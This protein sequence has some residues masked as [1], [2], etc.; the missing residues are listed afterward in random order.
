MN[1]IEKTSVVHNDAVSSPSSDNV[2]RDDASSDNVIHGF[3]TDIEHLP[4]G[5]YYSPFFIGS[6]LAVALSLTCGV[7]AFGY[8]APLLTQ[9][10]AELGPDPMFVWV[11]LVYNVMLSVGLVLVGRLS[12]IFGRRYFF[13]GGQVIGVLGCVVCAKSTSVPMLIGKF[14]AKSFVHLVNG[15]LQVETCFW[16]SRQHRNCRSTSPWA[17]W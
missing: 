5:Y 2:V 14:L 16:V 1:E 11:S 13:I 7:A 9:I 3:E 15:L 10:N 4:P 8:A 6:M 17:N 12:D